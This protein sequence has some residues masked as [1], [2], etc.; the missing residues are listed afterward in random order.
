M[1]DTPTPKGEPDKTDIPH[2]GGCHVQPG[3]G[4]FSGGCSP[5]EVRP[6]AADPTVKKG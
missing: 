4:A 5:S 2:P 3:S 1:A 6:E